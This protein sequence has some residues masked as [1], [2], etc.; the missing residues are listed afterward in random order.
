MRTTQ[1][2]RRRRTM[3]WNNVRVTMWQMCFSSLFLLVGSEMAQIDGDFTGGPTEHE[4]CGVFGICVSV[5]N[6]AFALRC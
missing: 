4:S 5:A 3:M 1:Q 2:S 6:V